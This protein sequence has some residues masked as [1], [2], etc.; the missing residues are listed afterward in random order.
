MIK[1]AGHKS[2]ENSMDKVFIVFSRKV[3]D[4]DRAYF[5][6]DLGYHCIKPRNGH[7]NHYFGQ[8]LYAY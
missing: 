1:R 6:Q 5:K 3:K 2:V 8:N 4:P 7:I